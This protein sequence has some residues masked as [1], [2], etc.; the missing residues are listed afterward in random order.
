MTSFNVWN[1]RFFN[2]ILTYENFVIAEVE[3]QLHVF[4]HVVFTEIAHTAFVIAALLIFLRFS[5]C[6]FCCKTLHVIWNTRKT[7]IKVKEEIPIQDLT[8]HFLLV[9]FR[10]V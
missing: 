9:L 2:I 7:L 1:I 4:R 5:E 8:R 3:S 6:L 10:F